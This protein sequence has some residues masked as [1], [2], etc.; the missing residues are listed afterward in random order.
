MLSV[1][2]QDPGISKTSCLSWP[3]HTEPPTIIVKHQLCVLLVA[4]GD[5]VSECLAAVTPSFLPGQRHY[6]KLPEEG[7][8]WHRLMLDVW[9]TLKGCTIFRMRTHRNCVFSLHLEDEAAS[10]VL[11]K[12]PTINR[13]TWLLISRRIYLISHIKEIHI[14]VN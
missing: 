5:Q 3:L 14:N 1:N 4:R 10:L 8:R 6:T 11:E 2:I 7:D 13:V 9:L 12:L